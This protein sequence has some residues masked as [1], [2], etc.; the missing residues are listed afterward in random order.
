MSLIGYADL[1]RP[2]AFDSGTIYYPFGG[3]A[4]QLQPYRCGVATSHT[5]QVDFQLDLIRTLSER[6]AHAVLSS[7]ITADYAQETALA[8]IRENSAGTAIAPMALTDWW[9][10]LFDS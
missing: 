8:R 4:Y 10:R 5:G 3:G 6:D 1:D 9:F 2:I 7:T